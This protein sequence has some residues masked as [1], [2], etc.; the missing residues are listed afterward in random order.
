[1][2]GL[3]AVARCTLPLL[4]EHLPAERSQ[5]TVIDFADVE[6]NARW[7]TE[8]GA[9]FERDRIE[10]D[11]YGETLGR[12]VGPGDMIVDLAWNIGTAD[13]LE[14]CRAHDVRYV[15]TSLEVWDPYADM[16]R[17]RRPSARST[18]G[19]W[20]CATASRAGATT[21]GRPPC[22]TTAPTPA[23][24]RTSR[25]WR[26]WTSRTRASPRAPA[27][28]EAIEAA[29]SDERVEQA[30]A[31]ARREDDPH[32]RARHADLEPAQA[33]ERVRQHLVGRGLL[34]GGHR[35][36]GDGLGH[37]REGAAEA[38]VHARARPA[39]PD[40]PGA[41]RLPHLGAV[42]GARAATSSAW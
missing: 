3:G 1:M 26:S 38:R 37:A 8:Q 24:S 42:V 27:T 29:R 33:G 30:G 19:T 32:L 2:I 35:A 7:V 16:A 18:P 14:W 41:S 20:S 4:F 28:V 40:L 21:T 25:R 6:E 34:R 13:I 11:S 36:G 39:Q 17:R 23:W 12:Y 10:R 31:G 15:N 22:S 5:Y 9:R